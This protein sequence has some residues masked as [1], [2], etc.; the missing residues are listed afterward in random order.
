MPDI[1]ITSPYYQKRYFALALDPIHVGTGGYRLGRVDN[2]IVRDPATGLPKI[3]GSSLAGVAR[4]YTAMKE[5][6]YPKCAGSG[7]EQGK[8]HCGRADC[9]VCVAY[10]FSNG[11]KGLSF[12]GLAQFT[13]IQ[14]FLFPVAS[15]YGPVWVTSPMTLAAAGI[16]TDGI[17]SEDWLSL[18]SDL[19]VRADGDGAK[20]EEYFFTHS[21]VTKDRINLGWLYLSQKK[22]IKL[23]DK[24]IP[25]PK[26]WKTRDSGAEAGTRLAIHE[27]ILDRLLIISDTLFSRV[28]NDNLEI[29]TSVAIDPNTGAA[30]DG[31]LF[32]YEAIPRGTVL[33]FDITFNNPEYFHVP[34]SESDEKGEEKKQ[35]DR[36]GL[37]T[38]DLRSAVEGGLGLMEYLGIG[39]MGT[40]GMGR[41]KVFAGKTDRGGEDE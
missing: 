1:T 6:K 12:Q 9:K 41:L 21:P 29:R 25:E 4:A 40:R 8:E 11:E 14:I 16:F 39:G 10:G 3:P 27:D 38:E 28:V 31:A 13:D 15:M 23:A 20:R 35:A 17:K 33:W 2:T 22:D 34:I 37:S 5:G 24:D 32:T 30:E 19:S 18:N 7:G 36:Q 26:D